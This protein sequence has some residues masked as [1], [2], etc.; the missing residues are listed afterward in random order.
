MKRLLNRIL[1]AIMLN[2]IAFTGLIAAP[3]E[4]TAT[5]A[6]PAG[7]Q[8]GD[9]I[10]FL[11]VSPASAGAGGN[12][13]I[14]IA[15]VRGNIAAAATYIASFAHAGAGLWRETGRIN[16]NGYLVPGSD[17]HNFTIDVNTEYANPRMRIR[18]IR[19][20]GVTTEAIGVYIKVRSINE[21]SSWT[22]L[23]VTGNDLSVNKFV[24]MTNDWSLYVGNTVSA[25]GASI[26]IK[27]IE[28]GNVG[29][30]TATPTDK[31]SVK[32]KIRA[33][34][35]KVETNG[36]ADFVFAKGYQ[37]P[38]LQAT[39]QHIIAR[40]H[41]PGIPSAIEVAKEGIELG[42]MNKR[43]LQKIEELTLHLIQKDKQISEMKQSIEKQDT[44][45]KQILVRMKAQ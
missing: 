45:I 20:L 14:S 41:L 6:F 3:S 28:N 44:A 30:G 34:E 1:F 8:T 17:G 42:E 40:G 24:P 31:L 18:A 16:S 4:Y 38:S 37:L 15:Y 43:L 25:D 33:Q 19:T 29:I 5:L 9:Y 35:I 27:A 2:T 13:E 36:W 32:G 10:E 22:T 12:Y 11:R 39:E 26:A 7:F 21:N 23:N